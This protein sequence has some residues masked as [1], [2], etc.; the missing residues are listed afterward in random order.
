VATAEYDPLRDDGV[1]YADRLREAGVDVTR[2]HYDGMMHGFVSLADLID[3]GQA[4]LTAAGE[5]LAAALA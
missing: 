3:D 4:A 2:V 5:A 1:L